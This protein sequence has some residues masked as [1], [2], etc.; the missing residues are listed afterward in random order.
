MKAQ[1]TDQRG[2]Q[3]GKGSPEIPPLVDVW[4][5]ANF[6]P[7]SYATHEKRIPALEQQCMEPVSRS[8]CSSVLDTVIPKCSCPDTSPATNKPA[9]NRERDSKQK[10]LSDPVT[11]EIGKN[12]MQAVSG[13]LMYAHFHRHSGCPLW[14]GEMLNE[15]HGLE[16]L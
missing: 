5:T 3:T 9:G 7:Y 13:H 8:D 16:K 14:L 1:G 15:Q 2:K 12:K 10:H 6:H 11:G 4:H